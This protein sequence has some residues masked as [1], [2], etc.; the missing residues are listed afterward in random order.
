MTRAIALLALMLSI[1]SYG[2]RTS[3]A[4]RAAEPFATFQAM[5]RQLSQLDTQLSQVKLILQKTNRGSIA[6]S[7]GKMARQPWADA[8]MKIFLTVRALDSRTTLLRTHY[9]ANSASGKLLTRLATSARHLVSSA[10]TFQRS[11]TALKAESGFEDL[12]QSRVEFLM[13]FHAVTSDYGALRCQR[14]AWGCC[15]IVP[16]DGAASC[17]WRCVEESR[18]CTSGLLGPRSNSAG[19][20]IV[21]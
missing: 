15:D 9:R 13:A 20:T 3:P 1:Q 7:S 6:T 2:Q 18:K 11:R 5:D 10:R 8:G 14:G 12:Q 4:K 21:H 19:S 17:H 16:K